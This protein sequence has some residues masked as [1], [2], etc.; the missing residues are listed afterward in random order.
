MEE[1]ATSDDFN[2]LENE[3]SDSNISQIISC[4]SCDFTC[5]N[6][7]NLQSHWR[8]SPNC[9]RS[10]CIFC[11]KKFDGSDWSQNLKK[12][13]KNIHVKKDKTGPSISSD[14]DQKHENLAN[15]S[16]GKNNA[17]KLIYLL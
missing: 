10:T 3:N 7:E 11:A 6:L 4:D 9:R 8:E 5:E 2:D 16:K 1:S 15:S 12:H 14:V 17:K 13:I